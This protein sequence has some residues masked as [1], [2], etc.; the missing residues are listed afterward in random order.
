[1]ADLAR[2]ARGIS[3]SEGARIPKNL[4]KPRKLS[5]IVVQRSHR[6]SFG[7]GELTASAKQFGA[8]PSCGGKGAK[9]TKKELGISPA[10]HVLSFTEGTPRRKGKIVISNEERNLS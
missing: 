8:D 5:R 3:E 7:I 2:L 1:M 10:K 4:R 6:K 9:S